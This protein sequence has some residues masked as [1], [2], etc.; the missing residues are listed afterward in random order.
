M[1]KKARVN[2]LAKDKLPKVFAHI[3]NGGQSR[4]VR[5]LTYK[6]KR[7]P[8]NDLCRIHKIARS[9]V[10]MRI[11]NGW[12]EDELFKRPQRRTI[13]DKWIESRKLVGVHKTRKAKI[14]REHLNSIDRAVKKVLQMR[15]NR[16]NNV[17]A[18]FERVMEIH[19]AID[20]VLSM[21][22]SR[23]KRM[24]DIRWDVAA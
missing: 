4:K 16:L 23:A 19:I 8:L 13:S 14:R 9:T 15:A 3:L 7:M 20:K 21:R 11:K 10:F 18:N 17:D 22:K 1:G 2:F 12:D 5:M 6:G 24:R